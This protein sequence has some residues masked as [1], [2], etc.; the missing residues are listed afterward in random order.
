[1]ADKPS[2][3]TYTNDNVIFKRYINDTTINYFELVFGTVNWIEIINIV[4]SKYLQIKL[5]LNFSKYFPEIKNK[6]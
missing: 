2:V 4:F 3:D 6:C 5:I 1:M